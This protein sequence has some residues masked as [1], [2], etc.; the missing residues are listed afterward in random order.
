MWND[1]KQTFGK[2]SIK[3]TIEDELYVAQKTLLLCHTRLEYAQADV[4][5]QTQRVARLSKSLETLQPAPIPK[6]ER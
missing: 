3:K 4:E 5:A 6:P 2:V 1:F